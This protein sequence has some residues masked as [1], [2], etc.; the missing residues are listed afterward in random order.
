MISINKVAVIGSGV[1]GAGIA[2][3][4]ANAGLSCLMLDLPPDQLTPKEEAA[5][6]DLGH[7]AVRNRLAS[8]AI[9]KMKKAK[10]AL[11]YEERFAERITAGNL[12]DD[13]AKL[14]EVD[15][16]IEVVVERLEVKQN[17]MALIETV[18]KPGIIV[19]SNT[20]GISIAAIAENCSETFRQHFMGTHFFNPPRYMPLLELIAGP[21]TSTV[22]LEEMKYFAERVLGKGVVFAKDTPNFIANRI[23]TYGLLVT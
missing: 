20:S 14:A 1:M 9:D 5:N 16:I 17:V 19:S 7:P 21:V 22:L 15:W 23:G 6:R 3:H 18:W 13:L 8:E 12:G 11:L 4:I 10:L 2:A